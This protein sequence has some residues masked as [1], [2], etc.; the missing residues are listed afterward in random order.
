MLISAL[1]MVCEN[2]NLFLLL[3]I[4]C[5]CKFRNNNNYFYYS[6]IY[7]F[8][9]YYSFIFIFYNIHLKKL[10]IKL[11]LKKKFPSFDE[12][13]IFTHLYKGIYFTVKCLIR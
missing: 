4:L 10:V 13:C 8:I 9:V 3:K 1:K 11:I 12:Y 2:R 5:V 6:F 7:F